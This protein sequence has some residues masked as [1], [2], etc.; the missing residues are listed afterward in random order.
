MPSRVAVRAGCSMIAV[1][2]ITTWV[3]A[4]ARSPAENPASSVTPTAN[5]AIQ[6]DD[7]RMVFLR[8]SDERRISAPHDGRVKLR[9]SGGGPLLSQTG[10]LGTTFAAT[11]A[12]R[13]I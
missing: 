4:A 9:N 8:R 5:V 3:S 11:G 2:S 6:R 13:G 7:V 12:P 10:Q 1:D